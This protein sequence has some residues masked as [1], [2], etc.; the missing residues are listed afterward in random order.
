[1]CIS[2]G[3]AETLP[4][5]SKSFDLVM[6]FTVFTSILAQHVKQRIANEMIRVVKPD[7][8]IIWYDFWGLESKKSKCPWNPA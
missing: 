6:Q 5:A 8:M 2:L 4:F 3:N 7:G 1:M